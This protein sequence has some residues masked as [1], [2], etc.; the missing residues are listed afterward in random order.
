M[1]ADRENVERLIGELYDIISTDTNKVDQI[2][3]TQMTR[4]AAYVDAYTGSQTGVLR[5]AVVEDFATLFILQRMAAGS[6]GILAINLGDISLGEKPIAVQINE[7]R[8]QAQE[9][10]NILGRKSKTILTQS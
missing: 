1:A 7:L 10:L 5:D 3:T 4:A 9:K 8:R 6:S 2:I